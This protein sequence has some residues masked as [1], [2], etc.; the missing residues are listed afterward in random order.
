MKK[1]FLASYSA[2]DLI[3]I[4]MCAGLGIAVKPVITP[5]AHIITGPLLIPGGAVAGGF[6]M[7]FIVLAAGFTG[8][9]FAATLACAVQAVLVVVTGFMGSHGIFSLI[10]YT[11][12]GLAA[13]LFRMLTRKQ[14]INALLC[15]VMGLL[16][17]VTGT[18]G[19][20]LVFFRLPIVPLMLALVSAALSGGLGGL[21]AWSVIKQIR[22]LTPVF[23]RPE[24]GRTD[25]K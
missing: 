18:L 21:I 3:V 16:A 14:R 19:S 7:L 9:R 17:N 8:S 11:A 13:D 25:E 5:L 20:N 1:R 4:A 2:F 23:D 6:Y 24:R 12:P 10:T 22:K 15:F